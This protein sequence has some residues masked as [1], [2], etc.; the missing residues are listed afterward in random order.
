MNHPR[1]Q[2]R[3]R[4]QESPV[5]IPSWAPP[6]R[7]ALG[8]LGPW[9]LLIPRHDVEYV[10]GDLRH[11]VRVALVIAVAERGLSCWP[12]AN[13]AA[14]ELAPLIAAD[15]GRPRVGVSTVRRALSH[16]T[17]AEETTL[18]LGNRSN[19]VSNDTS[20]GLSKREQRLSNV[21]LTEENDQVDSPAD[22]VRKHAMTAPTPISSTSGSDELSGCSALRT[23]ST[24]LPTDLRRRPKKL[25]P[26]EYDGTC[27]LCHSYFDDDEGQMLTPYK[28]TP[29]V[30]CVDHANLGLDLAQFEWDAAHPLEERTTRP[31]SKRT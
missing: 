1:R 14:I 18:A 23:Y 16:W 30:F 2:A 19:P 6:C 24:P 3:D 10:S 28:G 22:A 27:F 11:A 4:Q 9:A 12:S 21:E 15:L 31:A 5:A 25:T 17:L 20:N 29:R 13:A 7:G 26:S 8:Q